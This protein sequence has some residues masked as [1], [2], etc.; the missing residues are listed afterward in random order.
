M[1]TARTECGNARNLCTRTQQRRFLVFD[2]L[3]TGFDNLAGIELS[4]AAC[5]HARDHRRCQLAGGRQQPVAARHFP[6][7]V[8]I[9]FADHAWTHIVAPVVELL[10]HLVFDQLAFFFHHQD[11]VE[12]HREF[13]H[14]GRLQWPGHADLHQADA[15]LGGV[16]LV[17]AEVFQRLQHIEIALAGGDD[18]Q[19]RLVAVDGDAIELVGAAVGQ[20]RV[21]LALLQSQLLLH[22]RI[23]PA[24]RDARGGHDEILRQH[25][26]R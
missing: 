16:T 8:I 5:D 24:D 18:A 14:R 2:E 17:D 11:F 9:V 1:R 21:N 12:S 23:R 19:A 6:L 15:D 22:R 26:F 3:E 10:F 7:A 13:A 25:D 20:C 4:D